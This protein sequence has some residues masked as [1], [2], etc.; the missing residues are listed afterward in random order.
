MTFYFKFAKL[1]F[2]YTSVDAPNQKIAKAIVNKYRDD[3]ICYSA[4]DYAVSFRDI[5]RFVFRA[6]SEIKEMCFVKI[7]FGYDREKSITAKVSKFNKEEDVVTIINDFVSSDGRK[8]KDIIKKPQ[9]IQD[10][11]KSKS[12]AQTLC[13]KWSKDVEDWL[14]AEIGSKPILNKNTFV[15][16]FMIEDTKEEKKNDQLLIEDTKNEGA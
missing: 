16:I 4:T 7:T 15:P 8:L 1:P 5:G 14:T 6:L 12:N 10:P 2:V 3:E 13:V 11:N 9:F